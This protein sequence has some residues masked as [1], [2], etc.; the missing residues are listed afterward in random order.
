MH[1]GHRMSAGREDRR[2]KHLGGQKLRVVAPIK[3][4]VTL[5]ICFLSWKLWV[6]GHFLAH[7]PLLRFVATIYNSEVAHVTCHVTYRIIK[8]YILRISPPGL[9]I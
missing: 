6:Q 9:F 8:S 7:K 3:S 1:F 4:Q 5:L 2:P